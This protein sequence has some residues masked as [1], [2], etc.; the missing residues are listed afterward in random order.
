LITATSKNWE[1]KWSRHAISKTTQK[2][3]TLTQGNQ[4]MTPFLPSTAGGLGQSI[5][6]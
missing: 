5:L 1:Q 4:R 2:H 3:K 6:W